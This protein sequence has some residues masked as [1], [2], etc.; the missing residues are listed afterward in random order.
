MIL[1][2]IVI[3][4]TLINACTRKWKHRTAYFKIFFLKSTHKHL[5]MSHLS[6]CP[7]HSLSL[8]SRPLSP[9][10]YFHLPLRLCS[11]RSSG[12]K[13]CCSYRAWN[14]S[15]SNHPCR[16]KSLIVH[17]LISFELTCDLRFLLLPMTW[18]DSLSRL[19]LVLIIAY[20]T[21]IKLT[22]VN[23]MSYH[24]HHYCDVRCWESHPLNIVYS[25]L[26]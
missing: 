18:C 15:H 5:I 11:R 25:F 23:C 4:M 9:L 6:L 7:S 12:E 22:S 14:D 2:K 16:Y 24:S 21:L 26:K 1:C 13:R 10:S 8:T 17:C 20:C 19:Y 3:I